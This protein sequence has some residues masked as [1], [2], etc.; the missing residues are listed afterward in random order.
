MMPSG[1]IL[2]ELSDKVR[3]DE[4]KEKLRKQSRYGP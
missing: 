4:A 3:Y 2:P 1:A